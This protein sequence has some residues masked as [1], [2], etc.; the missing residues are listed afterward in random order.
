MERGRIV[1]EGTH[2]GVLAHNSKYAHFYS[3][4]VGAFSSAGCP[5]TIIAVAPR[6]R[7]LD[8]RYS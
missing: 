1:E 4:Q 3:L 5:P 2:R 6:F 8:R 7:H